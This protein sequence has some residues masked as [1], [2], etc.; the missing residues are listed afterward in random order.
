IR[1]FHVTGVQTCALPIESATVRLLALARVV[2]G[3]RA[4]VDRRAMQ[5][6]DRRATFRRR[7][8]APVRRARHRLA[9]TR[10]TLPHPLRAL[11]HAKIGRA[12]CRERAR[13]AP[14]A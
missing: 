8:H 9:V 10:R 11:A 5:R 4:D 13:S 2:E 14:L 1:D 12:S 3:E 6:T 7:P